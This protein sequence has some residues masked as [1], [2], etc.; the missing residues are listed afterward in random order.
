MI[1]I[2]W[3]LSFSGSYSS[4]P[5]PQPNAVIR[6]ATSWDESILSKRAFSTFRILPFKGKI[7]WFLRLRPCLAEPPAES[8]STIYSSDNAGSFSWQ[9]ASFPG[10]PARSSAPF[11]R[12]ISRA[13]LA[14]SLARAASII[15]TTMILLSPGFSNKNSFNFSPIAV[16]TAGLTSEETSL[17][18]V[19][20]E[21]LGSGTFTE[22]TAVSPSRASSPL[23]FVFAFL[24]IPSFSIKLFRVRVNAPLKPAKWL[25]PSRWGI[26]LVKQKTFSWKL[27]FHCIDSSTAIPSSFSTL[28]WNIF[29]WIGVLFWFRYS[30]KALMPPSY[31]KV[32]FFPSLS[33]SRI[34]LTPEF[35]NDSS[36]NLF[37][38]I[39]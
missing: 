10:K 7:A 24:A 34:M 15:L 33:S 31:W 11:L 1:I 5:I 38:R 23:A 26:L 30:T 16:S 27:S 13:F 29:W 20:D 18:L 22:I 36:R 12:V 4:R 19:W 21:N 32:S 28:K 8:P 35:R 39:S 9:S 14:A 25:P 37:A 3:Y 6:V 17:S 2:L